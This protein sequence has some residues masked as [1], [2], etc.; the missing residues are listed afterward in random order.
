MAG[1]SLLALCIAFLVSGF[2][3]CLATTT[4]CSGAAEECEL[5]EGSSGAASLLQK[6]NKIAQDV[7]SKLTEDADLETGEASEVA[8]AVSSQVL[9]Q[10]SAGAPQAAPTTTAAGSGGGGGGGC[11]DTAAWVD[12]YGDGCNMYD[13]HPSW[14]DSAEIWAVGGV[15]AKDACCVCGGGGAWA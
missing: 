6:K 14:C 7:S 13:S 1:M 10:G 9:S 11:T 5:P 3:F 2:P 4:E 8:V 15:S 12:S